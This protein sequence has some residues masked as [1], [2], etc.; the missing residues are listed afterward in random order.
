MTAGIHPGKVTSSS[1][2]RNNRSQPGSSPR[3]YSR[4][5]SPVDS[6][7]SRWGRGCHLCRSS[8]GHGKQGG[9]RDSSRCRHYNR[10]CL[11]HSRCRRYSNLE[12]WTGSSRPD[13]G[14]VCR[15]SRS[16]FGPSRQGDC[17]GSSRHHSRSCWADCSSGPRSRFRPWRNSWYRNKARRADCSSRRCCSRV[18]PKGSSW[19]RSNSRPS[20]SSWNRSSF[21]PSCSRSR[22][23]N[24]CRWRKGK[25]SHSPRRP[26]GCRLSWCTRRRSSLDPRCM[27]GSRRRS[28]CC[29]CR[30]CNSRPP[31]SSLRGR[32]CRKHRF[33]RWRLR[34]LAPGR[35]RSGCRSFEASLSPSKAH[36]RGGSRLS[37]QRHS[38]L[39]GSWRCRARVPCS[40]RRRPGRPSDRRSRRLSHYTSRAHRW[41]CRP[42]PRRRAVR[43]N[44]RSGLHSVACRI[45][46][47]RR[48][49]CL[50][51]RR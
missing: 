26:G 21:R 22:P 42:A 40:R 31:A 18:R 8:R 7:R 35:V 17:R 27:V 33:H 39:L 19:C 12:S 32:R 13:R 4:P 51:G 45:D 29:R 10:S 38:G 1:L 41:G 36:H 46:A 15:L 24:R 20:C 47:L 25:A 23:G 48:R 30:R 43:R 14:R 49:A 3:R 5:A 44:A 37:N 6:S 16:S 50:G 34:G 9:R 11:G 2:P 28:G